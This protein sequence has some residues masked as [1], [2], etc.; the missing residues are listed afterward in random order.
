MI[1]YEMKAI[2]ELKEMADH[3]E[4][5]VWEVVQGLT[6]ELE[7]S[8]TVNGKSVELMGDDPEE[9]EIVSEMLNKLVKLHY[10][11]LGDWLK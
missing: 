7:V 4:D 11:R 2:T 9:Y 3:Y 6:D 1:E 5:S 10:D 8:F